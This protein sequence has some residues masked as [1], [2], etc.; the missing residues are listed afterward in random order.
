MPYSPTARIILTLVVGFCA[1]LTSATHGSLTQLRIGTGKNLPRV[2]IQ[3]ITFLPSPARPGGR[4][5]VRMVL[6]NPTAVKTPAFRVHVSR[7]HWRPQIVHFPAG[8]KPGERAARDVGLVIV[9]KRPRSNRLCFG[10]RVIPKKGSRLQTAKHKGV[11]VAVKH[12]NNLR[13]PGPGTLKGIGT[14]PSGPGTKTDAPWEK[15]QSAK[16]D[17]KKKGPAPVMPTVKLVYTGIWTNT[18]QPR[19]GTGSGAWVL[20]GRDIPISVT[21]INWSYYHSDLLFIKIYKYP[22]NSTSKTGTLVHTG[23]YA[24]DIRPGKSHKNTVIV[25]N[26]VIPESEYNKVRTHCF[27]VEIVQSSNLAKRVNLVFDASRLKTGLNHCIYVGN[28]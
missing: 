4:L 5:G 25:S 1:L 3:K 14:S 24:R 23:F 6:V 8:L 12:G 19:R 27:R 28:Y 7:H 26:K 18:S 21:M 15:R 20:P 16:T 9:P 11:C 10:F 13:R 22:W 17:M 2:V